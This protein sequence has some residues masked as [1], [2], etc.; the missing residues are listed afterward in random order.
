[1]DQLIECVTSTNLSYLTKYGVR[2]CESFLRYVEPPTTLVVYCDATLENQ[3]LDAYA[4]VL[5]PDPDKRISIRDLG[6][7]PG[8][9]SYVQD[10]A[11]RVAQAR[12]SGYADDP[13]ERL[14][15]KGYR[16]EWDAVT[17]GKKGMSLSFALL[18][19]LTSSKPNRRPRYIF[20]LDADG[21]IIQPMTTEFL[22]SLLGDKGIAHFART[23]P[24]TE[25]G[26][27]G[28]DLSAPGVGEFTREYASYWFD[29]KVFKLSGWADTHVFDAALDDARPYG[30]STRNLSTTPR[31]HVIAASPLG[32]YFDHQKGQRKIHAL[33]KAKGAAR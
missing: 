31:G 18:S 14:L 7:L 4:A 16:Y 29:R 1:M 15:A 20:W 33:A 10:A 2:L 3:S 27:I 19:R 22:V 13:D 25:T 30:L 21:V 5:P 24:H 23:D 6:A 32:Q 12:G 8:V 26:F 17:F 28:F 9:F 11:M